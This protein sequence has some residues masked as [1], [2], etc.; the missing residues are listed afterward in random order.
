M[1][2]L[3]KLLGNNQLSAVIDGAGG[4]LYNSY[5]KLM[6]TGGIIVNYGQT[7]SVKGASF[8]MAHV[9]KNIDVRGSIIGFRKEFR[10]MVKFINH[11]KIRP[12]AYHVWNE[13]N[14]I[15]Q[16]IAIIS[17]GQIGQ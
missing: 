1:A 6:R 15:N 2:D 7:A 3:K 10:S 9:L 11:H 14:S 8:S 5:P 12:V 4:P 13:L 17:N 16:V